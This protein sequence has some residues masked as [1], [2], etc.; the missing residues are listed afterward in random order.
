MRITRLGVFTLLF[1]SLLLSSGC[2]FYN[3]IMA[4]KDLVDGAK[5]YKDRKFPDAERLFRQ[6][7]NRDPKGDTVE[8][9]TAQ[10]SLAR[11][12]HSE[13]IGDRGNKGKAEDALAEYKKSLPMSLAELKTNQAAYTA[14]P[15]QE[16]A[17]REY[18]GSLSAV[19]STVSAIAGLNDS[20]QRPDDSK[21]WLNEVANSADYPPTARARSL[22]A[23][24]AKQNTCANDITDTEA[25]KK[26]VQKDGKPAFQYV[27]PANAADYTTL[28]QCIDEGMKLIDEALAL[29]PAEVKNAASLNP[30]TMT[31]TDIA[32]KLEI[33]KTW[34]SV[35]SY[36]ASLLVQSM[37]YS[38]MGGDTASRDRLKTESDAAKDAFT[39]LS[40]IDK[41]LQETLDNRAAAKAAAEAPPG[42]AP[43]NSNANTAK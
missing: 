29:E 41:K 2:G 22:S 30:D 27:K 32:L 10:L 17:Q 38:E 5:A 21:A 23:L 37:R 4:R 42:T 16:K 43:A 28:K 3:R 15:N 14:N 20:L 19:N 8:G 6:A 24:A 12:L 13:Y 26:T 40:D 7:A 39:Q 31:D 1:S 36:K 18:L 34:E 33:L 25:T 9:R 11:T 35:R